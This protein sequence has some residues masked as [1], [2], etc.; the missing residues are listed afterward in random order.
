MT[1][2]HES[3]R[4]VRVGDHVD[5]GVYV[6]VGGHPMWHFESGDPSG[7]PTVLVHGVFASAASW[8]TQIA[9]LTKAGLHLYLPERTGHGHTPDRPGAWS[10]TAAADELIGYLDGVV[11]GPAHLV[12]WSD[13][14]T[15]ALLVALRRPDLVSR[16]VVF[17]NYVN[18]TGS[19][20]GDFIDRIRAR[21]RGL[22]AFL[23]DGYQQVT[24]DGAAHFDVVY[25]KTASMLTTE[26]DYPIADFAAVAAPTLVV[27]ADRGVVH[28]EHSMELARMLPR[29]RLS[30]L[31]G[32]H[33]LPIEAPEMFNPLVVSY[34]AADPP[35]RWLI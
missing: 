16:M 23:R 35:S 15:I 31:P 12:G 22:V 6:D 11:G 27:A 32:T 24:P 1:D 2:T 33:L 10:L 19:A 14:A 13:G 20:A 8:G 3:T 18:P 29:G 17:G 5:A 25:D 26:P 28:L 30:I 9:D 34:L 7:P 21:E 4:E